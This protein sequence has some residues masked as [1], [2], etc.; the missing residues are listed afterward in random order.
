MYRKKLKCLV[1]YSDHT[2]D[3]VNP[4]AATALGAHIYEKH[5]TL[6]KNL[7]GP[8]HRMSL[9]PD[10]LKQTIKA[11]RDTEI[12]LGSSEKQ[13]LECETENRFKL[14]K[15]IVANTVIEKGQPITQMM[16]G[17]KRPAGG[18]SPAKMVTII[19]KKSNCQIPAGTL[20][21]IDMIED[22]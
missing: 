9:N 5:F 11:I 19:G 7:P 1:G 18:I 10:E 15:S 21:S 4:I 16:L 14:R 2:S 20:I 12:A 22:E 3:L 13:V 17:V 6:D 8:D